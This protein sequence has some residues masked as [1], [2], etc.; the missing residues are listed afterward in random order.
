MDQILKTIPS[1]K[2][3]WH[4]QGSLSNRKIIF[5]SPIFRCYVSFREGKHAW[6]DF[7]TLS[8]LNQRATKV[9]ASTE[10]PKARGSHSIAMSTKSWRFRLGF[11]AWYQGRYVLSQMFHVW[12]YLPTSNEKWPHE[13][14]EMWISI[15]YMEHLGIW[16]WMRFPVFSPFFSMTHVIMYL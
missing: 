7:P 4:L 15:P 2:L 10:S 3:I 5:Q 16:V 8:I 1:L 9:I 11:M 12:I 6:Y 13:Q 14:G